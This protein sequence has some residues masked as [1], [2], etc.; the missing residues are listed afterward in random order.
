M[1]RWCVS[2]V[3]LMVAGG[4]PR[5]AFRRYR[6]RL[7]VAMG[8]TSLE[9]SYPSWPVLRR[10]LKQDHFRVLRVEA[11][12]LLLLPYAWP[13]LAKHSG[14][15]KT[16]AGLDRAFARHRPWAWLGDHLLV[17]AERRA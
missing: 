14:L 16:L 6:R 10:A 13:A 11:L 9:V 17:V 5:Q 7:T 2:E 8:S 3:A 15:Y 12:L 1:N 4:R